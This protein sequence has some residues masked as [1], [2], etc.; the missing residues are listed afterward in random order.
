[1]SPS[2]TSTVP[3]QWRNCTFHGPGLP[4]HTLSTPL[5]WCKFKGHHDCQKG[6]SLKRQSLESVQHITQIGMQGGAQVYHS[7]YQHTSYKM[8]PSMSF[9]FI[10]F[11]LCLL[12]LSR[13]F[14]KYA[15]DTFS[16]IQTL[17]PS[18]NC[19]YLP[20]WKRLQTENILHLVIVESCRN[21]QREICVVRK[22]KKK[23]L[24]FWALFTLFSAIFC[25]FSNPVAC[26]NLFLLFPALS[27]Y[28]STSL[29]SLSS[30]TYFYILL[31][32]GSNPLLCSSLIRI[33]FSV[34]IFK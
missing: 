23:K 2:T 11:L 27:L 28:P 34:S 7:Y 9:F 16:M 15:S 10:L 4:W 14:P 25:N 3:C 26:H 6:I 1:M 19:L 20:V 18:S 8:L 33:L 31:S 5:L 21:D 24:C 29:H 32:H 17:W 22:R 30:P 13:A 12:F